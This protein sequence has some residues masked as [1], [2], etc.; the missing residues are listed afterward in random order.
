MSADAAPGPCRT[1]AAGQF[2]DNPEPRL[3]CVLLLDSSEAMA[4]ER[5]ERLNAG[6]KTLRSLAGRDQLAARRIELAVVTFGGDVR[7]VRAFT[8]LDELDPPILVASGA[9]SLTGGLEKA[10]TLIDAQRGL[11][12]TEG[13]PY[14][15]PWVFLITAA[16]PDGDLEA[17]TAL[18]RT[19]EQTKRLAC[20]GVAVA[21]LDMTRLR[22]L[23]VREPLQ[24]ED[25]QFQKLFSWLSASL[26]IAA[27]SEIFEDVVP[28]PT[29][30]WQ[31]RTTL[32][33]PDGP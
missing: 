9:P 1:P 18:V 22:S 2:A 5:I 23:L 33:E 20:F 14:H 6:V 31:K 29:I 7:V 19:S 11:Y 27:Y 26:R 16:S 32:P 12:Q 24:L 13:I 15:R 10:V 21:D 8:A 3:A 28:L 4:G 25:L 30:D 17:I